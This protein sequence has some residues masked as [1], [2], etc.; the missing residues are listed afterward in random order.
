MVEEV[1]KKKKEEKTDTQSE[2]EKP[3]YLHSHCTA[4]MEQCFFPSQCS[5]K[6][7]F[8]GAYVNALFPTV[9][10]AFR[11]MKT[12]GVFFGGNMG[13]GWGASSQHRPQQCFNPCHTQVVV[14]TFATMLISCQNQ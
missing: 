7:F 8:G 3:V 9:V 10:G 5:G 2:R 4:A 1:L 13:R 11:Q 14:F 6:D 12:V